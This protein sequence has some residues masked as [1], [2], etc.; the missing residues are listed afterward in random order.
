MWDKEFSI[1]RK[2]ISYVPIW[3]REITEKR[4]CSSI[5]ELPAI[6]REATVW[7]ERERDLLEEEK[8]IGNWRWGQALV[9]LFQAPRSRAWNYAPHLIPTN[10]WVSQNQHQQ[11]ACALEQDMVSFFFFV[12][13]LP[14]FSLLWSFVRRDFSLRR[15]GKKRVLWQIVGKLFFCWGGGRGFCVLLLAICWKSFLFVWLA[16][17][18]EEEPWLILSQFS[19]LYVQLS[20]LWILLTVMWLCFMYVLQWLEDKLVVET[21]KARRKRFKSCAHAGFARSPFNQFTTIHKLVAT[22]PHTLGVGL[23]ILAFFLSSSMDS[24]SRFSFSGLSP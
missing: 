17:W 6:V 10:C 24:V 4:R 2:S 7:I 14:S 15:V 18:I 19:W 9:L 23:E 20:L 22:T 5:F 16:V 1:Y 3:A 11:Q 8:Q 21:T 12:F 13:F